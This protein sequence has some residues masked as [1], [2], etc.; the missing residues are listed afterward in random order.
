M[1]A[2]VDA[3]GWTDGNLRAE[4]VIY[5]AYKN[6]ARTESGHEFSNVPLTGKTLLRTITWKEHG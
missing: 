3:P 5:V 1:S 4:S 6:H 2:V